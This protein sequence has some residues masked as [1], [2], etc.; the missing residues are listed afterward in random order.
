MFKA[1]KKS[2]LIITAFFSELGSF[3][4]VFKSRAA[5]KIDGKKQLNF[6]SICEI[7]VPYKSSY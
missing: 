1:I 3:E 4:T 7:I 6:K 5:A 2:I